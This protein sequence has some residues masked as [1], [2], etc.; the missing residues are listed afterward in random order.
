MS[1]DLVGGPRG[2]LPDVDRAEPVRAVI[3]IG[4]NLGDRQAA[5]DRAIE[6]IGRLPLTTGLGESPRIET[7]AL[8]LDGLDDEAPPYLNGVVIVAT[9]LAPGTLLSHLH[10]IERDLGRH[11]GADVPRWS[12]RTIDLDLIVYGAQIIDD[13]RLTLPHPRAAER[14]F[15]LQPW[16]ALDPDAVLPGVGRVSD[17][18]AA[19][20]PAALPQETGEA[21]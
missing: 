9:R 15:V 16:L 2:P 5:F 11:R 20:R 13:E 14:D 4:A 12:D 6:R 10:R 3:A 19:V 18:L 7:V 21:S 1:Q 8:T 17:L